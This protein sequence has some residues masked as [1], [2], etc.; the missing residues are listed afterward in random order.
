MAM[1]HLIFQG[2]NKP[3]SVRRADD[4]LELPPEGIVR[5]VEIEYGAW[6]VESA[7]SPVG[8]ERVDWPKIGVAKDVTGCNGLMEYVEHV[9]EP[10]TMSQ[11]GERRWPAGRGSW[12]D[13]KN[14]GSVAV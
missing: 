2:V 11:T 1:W 12:G 5:Y 6:T 9:P 10:V 7:T 4:M 14:V 3:I 13:R 8:L